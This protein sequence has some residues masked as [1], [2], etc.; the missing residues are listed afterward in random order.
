[1]IG[2]LL[3]WAVLVGAAYFAWLYFAAG[4]VANRWGYK[5]ANFLGTFEWF[6]IFVLAGQCLKFYIQ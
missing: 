6:L 2:G 3:V 5:I 4:T 1:M